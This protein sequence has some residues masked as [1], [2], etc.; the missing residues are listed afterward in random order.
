MITVST[1]KT[2]Y[3]E[4]YLK[5]LCRHFSH[6]IPASIDG[7][8]G[9]LE[10][11]FGVCHIKID[12][13]HMHIRIRVNDGGDLDRAEKVIEEHLI[14]IANRDEPVVKWERSG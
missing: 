3:A 12:D 9:T 11:P 6:K 13:E 5:R 1:V 4:P 8:R 7:R 10:F 14:R 2:P